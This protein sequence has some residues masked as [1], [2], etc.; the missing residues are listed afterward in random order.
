[1]I[2]LDSSL[3]DASRSLEYMFKKFK[4][5]I[6]DEI[7]SFVGWKYRVIDIGMTF[8]GGFHLKI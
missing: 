4:Y 8:S 5:L 6:K 2:S 1:M 7:H 3:D